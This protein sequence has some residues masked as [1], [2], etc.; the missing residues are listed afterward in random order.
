VDTCPYL[1]VLRERL[2]KVI[3]CGNCSYLFARP[4]AFHR[5]ISV[6]S[7]VPCAPYK[8]FAFLPS[9]SLC[10]LQ[11]PST[12]VS[13]L[14]LP[15]PHAISDDHGGQELDPSRGCMGSFLGDG[16]EDGGVGPR[17]SSVI[18]GEPDPSRMEGAAVRP[19]EAGAPGG[20]RG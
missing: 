15:S 7:G 10:A 18:E 20:I 17:W 4:L 6:R 9:F 2:G 13:L 11:P 12:V 16:E 1:R 3:E 8:P 19:S 14:P 5:G